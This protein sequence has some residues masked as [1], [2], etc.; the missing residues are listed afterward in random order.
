MVR[1]NDEDLEFIRYAVMVLVENLA[2]NDNPFM[3]YT[4]LSGKVDEVC[5]IWRSPQ[6]LGPLLGRIQEHCKAE[7]LPCLP[8]LVVEQGTTIPREGFMVGYRGLFPELASVRDE[9]IIRME[10]IRCMECAYWY[11]LYECVELAEEV[12]IMPERESY[13]RI[14]REG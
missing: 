5:G 1:L 8:S 3:T 14:V 12:P 13:L 9:L 10:Q 11:G 6:D 2:R 7:K 4:E